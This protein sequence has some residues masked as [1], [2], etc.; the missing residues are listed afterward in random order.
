MKKITLFFWLITFLGYSQDVKKCEDITLKI[1]AAINAKDATL[2]EPYLADDFSI[3]GQT[4]YIARMVLPQLFMQL[5]TDITEIVK[6]SETKTNNLQLVYEAH[7]EGHGRRMSTFIFNTD[8]QIKEIILFES[9]VV[10]TL[11]ADGAIFVR[12]EKPFFSVPFKKVGNL[13]MVEAELNGQKR[14]FIVDNGA[15]NL[16]LNSAHLNENQEESRI[17]VSDAKGAGGTISDVDIQTVQSFDFA[18]ISLV[19]QQVICMNISHLERALETE[20]HGLLGYEVYES[21]DILFDYANQRIVF[22]QPEETHSFLRNNLK[23]KKWDELPLVM[24]E[25]LPTIK[26]KIGSKSYDLA[27]DCGAEAGLFD[28]SLFEELSKNLNNI[29]ETVLLGADKNE[30][31]TK[32][33]FIKQMKIGKKVFHNSETTFSDISHL[34]EGYNVKL[35][36]LIGYEVLSKQLTLLSFVNQK[37]FF[38]H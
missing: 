22:I 24:N 1:Y 4:G 10:K 9:M 21:Y 30:Q 27:V 29:S 6:I 2:L 14:N 8:N 25:H 36:G 23:K 13:I 7:F 37:L 12:N 5:N 20:I 11:D 16:I 32:A 28:K 17:N 38:I 26:A 19:D 33:A 34:N 31:T 3:A 15:P 18:G 35:N